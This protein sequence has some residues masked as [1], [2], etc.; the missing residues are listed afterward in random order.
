MTDNSQWISRVSDSH[1]LHAL[2]DAVPL[3]VIAYAVDG[4]VIQWNRAAETMF[5]WSSE[6]V[7]GGPSPVAPVVGTPAVPATD[8]GVCPAGYG[9]MA[10]R[11]TK[12]GRIVEVSMILVPIEDAE[13]R[14]HGSLAIVCDLTEARRRRDAQGNLE[15]QLRQ[16]QKMEAVAR[17]AGGVAHDFNNALTVITGHSEQ[18]AMRIGVDDARRKSVDAI[19]RA[20]ERSAWLTR[21]LLAFSRKQITTPRV[22]DVNGLVANMQQLL[23]RLMGEDVALVTDLP[24]GVGRIKADPTQ[25]EQVI[26][27]LAVNARD[28]MPRGGTLVIATSRVRRAALPDLRGLPGAEA[29]DVRLCVSDTGVGMDQETLGHLFE[30]FFTTKEHGKGTG[31]GLSTVYGIVTQAGGSIDV[32]SQRGVGTAFAMVFPAA[33]EQQPAAPQGPWSPNAMGTETI[34]LVEDEDDVRALLVEV[35]EQC[36]YRVLAATGGVEAV[37]LSASHEG[38][39]HLLITDMIMPTCGGIEVARRITAARPPTRVLFISGYSEHQLVQEGLAN[40]G[41]SFLHKPFTPGGLALRVRTLLDGQ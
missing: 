11:S 10:T 19:A 40:A 18:L 2:L 1:V 22:F 16:A 21:Q 39:I 31:L 12:N 5:G 24:P 25:I 36:G 15:A 33:T 20:A 27:N 14:S 9:A 3:A 35:L 8:V 23:R 17:L 30:P 38:P 29:D 4:T 34:L 6:E 37:E 28:A 41:A 13:G 7:V 32:Q 26:M